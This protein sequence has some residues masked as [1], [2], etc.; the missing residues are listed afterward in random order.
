MPSARQ[1]RRRLGRLRDGALRDGDSSSGIWRLLRWSWLAIVEFRRALCFERAANLSFTTLLSLIPLSVL[2]FSFAGM[3]GGGDQIVDW[4]KEEGLRFLAPE[5][6]SDLEGWLDENISADAFKGGSTGVVNTVAIV[7]LLMAALSLLGAAERYFNLIWEIKSK[8]NYFHRAVAFWCILTTSPFLVATSIS[9]GE[10]L[11]PDGGALQTALTQYAFLRFIY[12]LFVPF[13][14]ALGGFVMLYVFLP[15]TKVRMRSATVGGLVAAV[16]WTASKYG[17]VLYVS[18]QQSKAS[19]YGKLATVPLVLVWIYVS[20]LIVLAGAVVS[21]TH[22]NLE[23]LLHRRRIHRDGRSVSRVRIGMII[24][25]QAVTAFRAGKP[26]VPRTEIMALL[27]LPG[28]VVQEVAE[29]LVDLGVLLPAESDDP[30]WVPARPP[31]EISLDLVARR[32]L[33]DEFAEIPAKGDPDSGPRILDESWVAFLHAMATRTA[34]DLPVS[35]A[36][37]EA[38]VSAESAPATD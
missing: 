9:I 3:L 6:H 7:G 34:A 30:A 33:S 22:Q 17:F 29:A 13:V 21:Y 23:G 25:E 4:V 2:F 14:I 27:D 36:I 8:R 28:P 16:L 5:V 37:P 26:P 15:A 11:V 10:W 35:P 38:P 20:W 12:E 32:L 31:E 19:F 24:L 1:I 18:S